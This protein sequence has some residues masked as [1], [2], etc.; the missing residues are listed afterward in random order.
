VALSGAPQP[1]YPATL[2]SAR[3]EGT[4]L[5]Q[6]VVDTAGVPDVATFKALESSHE[7]F[8]Q[9]VRDVLPRMRF[10]VAT[11]GDKK[12]RQVVQQAFVFSLP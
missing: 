9:A 5:A 4:V 11:M 10:S 8:T 1:A 6:F 3:V 2:R 7:L 12:V